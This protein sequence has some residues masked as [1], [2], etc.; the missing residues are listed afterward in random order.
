MKSFLSISF[1]F[2]FLTGPSNAYY[3]QTI[4][5]NLAV[6]TKIFTSVTCLREMN[7]DY[8]LVSYVG[9]VAVTVRLSQMNIFVFL[10]YKLFVNQFGMQRLYRKYKL[11]LLMILFLFFQQLNLKLMFIVPNLQCFVK[12]CTDYLGKIKYIIQ[13]M[14]FYFIF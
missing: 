9:Q 10:F 13:N 5:L 4:G 1:K 7:F 8:I 2:Q 6:I 14:K 3:I 12:Y 11:V